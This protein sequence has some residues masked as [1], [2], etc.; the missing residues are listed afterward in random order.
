MKALLV[1]SKNSGKSNFHRYFSYVHKELEPLYERLDFCCPNTQQEAFEVE[2][3]AYKEYDVLLVAGGDGTFNNAINA[4]M[5]NEKRPIIGYINSGTLGDV[6]KCFGMKRSVKSSIQVIKKQNIKPCDLGKITVQNK[7]RYFCYMAAAGSFSD[8]SYKTR[9]HKKSL[10]KF[11]YYW[12]AIKELFKK[13]QIEY[14]IFDDFCKTNFLMILNGP[15]VGG[16][17]VYKSAK[18]D[19]GKLKFFA[20]R[21]RAFHGL[22][23]Y[24]TGKNIDTLESDCFEI[25]LK[26]EDLTWCIDGE[27]FL[28]GNA[29]ISCEKLAIQT[30]FDR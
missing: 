19:D 6:G 3:N 9:K 25:E 16:F 13:R 23:S 22:C 24:V 7:S 4:I 18:L 20:S 28:D 26:G 27:A 17:K 5:Q 2:A 21:G 14:K 30:Y 1:Y 12:E 29:K 10:G 15:Y 8:I 11:S